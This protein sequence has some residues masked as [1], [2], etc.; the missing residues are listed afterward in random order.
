MTILT[1]IRLIVLYE[2]PPC[3]SG[4]CSNNDDDDDDDDD[5]HKYVTI[6]L[7]SI[8]FQPN[9]HYP[10]QEFMVINNPSTGPR[11]VVQESESHSWTERYA[12]NCTHALWK[13]PNTH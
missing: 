1:L 2:R 7:Y 6:K 13:Q 4:T 10:F 5:N 3:V 11:A 8:W 9:S 12:C